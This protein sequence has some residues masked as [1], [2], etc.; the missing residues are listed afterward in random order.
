MPLG[1]LTQS[2]QSTGLFLPESGAS[3]KL[4]HASV[5]QAN[6]IQPAQSTQTINYFLN[7]LRAAHQLLLNANEQT[8]TLEEIYLRE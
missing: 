4:L 3:R 6:C 2:S 8:K 1:S 7:Y 5:S